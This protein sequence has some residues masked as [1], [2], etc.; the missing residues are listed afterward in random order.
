[1]KG[2]YI[3]PR[4]ISIESANGMSTSVGAEAPGKTITTAAVTGVSTGASTAVAT[5]AVGVQPY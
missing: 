4:S 3:S 5:A 2:I 1:M